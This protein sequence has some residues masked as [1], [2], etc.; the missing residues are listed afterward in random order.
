MDEDAG[1][2]R[3][4]EHAALGGDGLRS[5]EVDDGTPVRGRREGDQ[6]AAVDPARDLA[7]I[8]RVGRGEGEGVDR[9]GLRGRGLGH[10]RPPE[11]RRGLRHEGNGRRSDERVGRRLLRRRRG[12]GEEQD[13]VG[14]PRQEQGRSGSV[15][16][17]THA[18]SVRS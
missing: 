11:G 3:G 4:A 12:G 2:S 7:E 14:P 17:P 1:G 18:T 16:H 8:E 15:Q 6:G 13:H 5:R 9:H 10:H